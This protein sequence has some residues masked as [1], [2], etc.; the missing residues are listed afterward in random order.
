MYASSNSFVNI[1]IWLRLHGT[2][3]L[4]NVKHLSNDIDHLIIND[5]DHLIINDN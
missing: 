3:T 2:N 1:D 5:I 4:N